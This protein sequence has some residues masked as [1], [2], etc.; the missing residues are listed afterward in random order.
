[1]D[2]VEA[3]GKNA[4]QRWMDG[5]P[6]EARAA[7]DV[8]ILQMSAMPKALWSDKWVSK[9]KGA[10]GIFELRIPHNKVQYRPLGCYGPGRMCFTLLAGAIE[11]GNKIEKSIVET[12]E[13]R[14]T[15]VFKD[16]KRVCNHFD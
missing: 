5:L 13:N 15:I 7:I 1:M 11:K 2:F 12:A 9:Y 14:H 10:E 6:A 3:N 16:P 4:I 8:R